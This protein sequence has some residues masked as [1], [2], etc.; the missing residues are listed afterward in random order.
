MRMAMVKIATMGIAIATVMGAR[1]YTPEQPPDI[2][3]LKAIAEE[4]Y[5]YG[6]TG[7]RARRG[8]GVHAE[9]RGEG[10][11]PMPGRK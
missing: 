3:E 7:D 8:A 11:A 2:D 10:D 1:P 4:A 5:L 6:F 9:T